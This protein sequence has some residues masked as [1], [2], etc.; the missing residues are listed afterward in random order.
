MYS[1]V[2]FGFWMHFVGF[3]CDLAMLIRVKYENKLFGLVALLAVSVYTV[4][5]VAWFI[6]IMV[7]RYRQSG[8]VCAELGDHA[9]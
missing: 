6:W 7:C 9:A 5:F 2:V 1:V 8:K 4:V 3:F